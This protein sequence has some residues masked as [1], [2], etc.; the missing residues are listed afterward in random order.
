MIEIEQEIGK[1]AQKR[2]DK[3]RNVS[4]H[5]N[6]NCHGRHVAESGAVLVKITPG[7]TVKRTFHLIKNN[8]MYPRRKFRE[9]ARKRSCNWHRRARNRPRVFQNLKPRPPRVYFI[10]LSKFLMPWI[11]KKP[12]FDVRRVYGSRYSTATRRA[13]EPRRIWASAI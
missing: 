6:A 11:R 10:F 5:L 9:D 13:Q 3:Q 1:S 2:A 8:Y 12:W 4:G 7:F